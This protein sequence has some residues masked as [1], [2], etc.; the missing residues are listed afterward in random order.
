MKEVERIKVAY[1]A[2]ER[3]GWDRRYSFFD[4]ANLL[5]IQA[6]E[7]RIL[8]L[9]HQHGLT[10]LTGRRILDVGCGSGG[11]LRNFLRWGAE[12][13]NL[14]GIDLLPE[15]I[16]RAR[17]LSP[18]INFAC[19]NAAKLPYPE[20]FFDLVTQFTVFTSILDQTMKQAI[21]AEM[22]RVLKPEGLILWYD[23]RYSNPANPNVRGVGRKEIEALFPA[24][25]RRLEVITLAPPLARKIA[26]HSGLACYLLEKIPF[27]CTHYLGV[28][29][30]EAVS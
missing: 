2:R 3:A 20:A 30:K 5:A 18:N 16:E 23:F 21:A 9:L 26:P 24:C 10:P 8:R 1:Q 15:R 6:R 12:P 7:R 19:G 14:Y 25:R 22:Q 28:I 17:Y 29:R 27:L 13:E 11:E 4:A